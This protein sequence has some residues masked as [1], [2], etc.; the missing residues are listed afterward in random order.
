MKI[1]FIAPISIVP[2]ASAGAETINYYIKTLSE[3]DNQIDVIAK[4]EGRYDNKFINYHILKYKES[5]LIKKIFKALGW[6]IYPQSKYL[7]KTSSSLRYAIVVKLKELKKKGYKPEVI[8][9]ETTSSILL[10]KNIRNIFPDAKLV[11]S[12]HDIAYQGSFRKMQLE[13]NRIRL[14]IRK[15]YLKYAI[16]N[17]VTALMNLDLIVPHNASNIKILKKHTKLKNKIYFP[18]VPFYECNYNHNDSTNSKNILFYGLM[19]RPENYQSVEWFIDYVMPK[20]HIDFKLV[21]IGGNPPRH[22]QDRE[23]DKVVI[24]GFIEENMV[25]EYFEN[26]FCIVVPLLFG[27]G[28]KTKVLTALASGLPVLTNEI[29]IEGINAMP[30]RDYIHCETVDEYIVGLEMLYQN[31]E[32]YKNI[33]KNARNVMKRSYNLERCAMHYNYLLKKI[34]D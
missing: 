31:K 25:K 10:Y 14:A 4:N 22:L 2:N 17:E 20:L 1:L 33:C 7:Y 19:S 9:L 6:V 26:A 8:L 18:L 12:L 27:S 21:V 29:G 28:I 13:T 16:Q 5:V 24:T 23:F 30:G 11:G 15:R 32:T 34:V 3:N